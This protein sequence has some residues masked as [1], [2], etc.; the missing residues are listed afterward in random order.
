MSDKAEETGQPRGVMVVIEFDRSLLN[1]FTVA[2]WNAFVA[3]LMARD[4][5][6]AVWTDGDRPP[7]ITVVFD[8][9]RL[10]RAH[11]RLDGIDLR[12]CYHD[13][14]DFIGASLKNA[15]L[16]FGKNACYRG[17]RL[18]GADFQ[19]IEI[20]GCDFTDCLGVEPAMFAGAVYHPANPPKGLPPEVLAVCEEETGEPSPRPYRASKPTSR[21][22]YTESP[23][24]CCAT[25][26]KDHAE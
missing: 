13:N 8:F 18:H 26:Q 23:L 12:L 16:G 24:R 2:E 4:L 20:S 5:I 3:D 14:A 7:P 15:R 10:L 19:G 22:Y 6:P 11:Y 25:I 1:H 9:R 21:T 17:A